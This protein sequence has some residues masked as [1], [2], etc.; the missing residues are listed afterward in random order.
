MATNRHGCGIPVHDIVLRELSFQ[1]CRSIKSFTTEPD[2]KVFLCSVLRFNFVDFHVYL[3]GLR[4]L[5]S[6]II[7]KFLSF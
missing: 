1:Y 3:T 5:N 7:R 2:L 6:K 4:D